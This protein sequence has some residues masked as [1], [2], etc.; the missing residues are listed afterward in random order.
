M[1]VLVARIDRTVNSLLHWTRTG[2]LKFGARIK[3]MVIENLRTGL[4]ED[5]GWN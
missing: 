1:V 4:D 3:V 2:L 5:E